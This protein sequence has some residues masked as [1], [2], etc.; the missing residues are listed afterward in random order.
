[1]LGPR[2][3]RR[4]FDG[5]GG[6]ILLPEAPAELTKGKLRR[7]GEG[8]GKVVYASEHWVVKRERTGFEILALVVLWRGLRRLERVL[9]WGL[10]RRL[11][12]R[13]AKQIRLLRLL[14]QAAL[15]VVPK[16]IWFREHI[17]DFWWMY[18]SRSRRGDSLAR[19]HLD[20]TELVPERVAFPPTHVE[21]GG[22]PG[23]LTVSEATER[24]EATL[25]Q[26]LSE[27]ARAGRFGELEEWLERFL[28]FRQA[29][30]QRGVFSVD[31]HLKN[32]GVIGGRIV[33][34]DAGGLTDRWGDIEDRLDF[35]D[36]VTQPH[37]QLG[38]GAI[39]GARPDIGARFDERWKAVVN[40]QVVRRHWPASP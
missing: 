8:V 36:V 37:V 1:M 13:P 16:S 23:W 20:G 4:G 22:W 30:W 24:V 28:K 39:L 25:H 11:A 26:R 7:L 10:G 17:K 5:S 2:P 32:F 40:R 3:D 21:V 27:L 15:L 38:L 29:G 35:E 9:P 33:L 34:L 6:P 14:V 19:R 12:D 18:R 31:A